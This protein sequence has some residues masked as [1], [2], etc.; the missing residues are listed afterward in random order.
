MCSTIL[1]SNINYPTRKHYGN[2]IFFFF[3]TKKKKKNGRS[4]QNMRN[5]EEKTE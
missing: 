4:Q 5:R 1:H 2:A 3:S